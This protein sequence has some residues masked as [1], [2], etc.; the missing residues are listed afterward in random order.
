MHYSAFLRLPII[1]SAQCS[2]PFSAHGPSFQKIYPVDR[3]AMLTF[4]EKP[5]EHK[6]LK[7]ILHKSLCSE[8]Y[9][10]QECDINDLRNSVDHVSA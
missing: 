8:G 5:V 9:I 10:F 6:N 1:S 4:H 3:F 2:Q 7:M